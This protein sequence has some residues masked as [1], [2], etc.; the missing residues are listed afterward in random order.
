VY[1][2]GWG[3]QLTTKVHP[4]LCILDV[5]SGAV[6]TLNSIPEDVSPG[7]VGIT[8]GIGSLILYSVLIQ[9]TQVC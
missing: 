8:Q 7:Q 9:C 5:E 1:K 2:E 4:I 3:E 6:T